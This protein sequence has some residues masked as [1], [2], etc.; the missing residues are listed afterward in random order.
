MEFHKIWS[1]NQTHL[2]HFIQ[3]KV[4]DK[5]LA[6]DILQEVSIKL[7]GSMDGRIKISNYRNWLFQVA[8]NTIADYY[9]KKG[10][11]D[12]LSEVN[13]NTDHSESA[14]VCDLSEF[15][16]Q[17][18]LAEK[19]S[20]PLYMSDILGLSQQHIADKLSISLS[21]TKSRIQRARVKLRELIDECLNISY[22]VHGQITDFELKKDCEIPQEL[23]D[24]MARIN[25]V[26]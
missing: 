14:C 20:R 13:M 1:T 15:V 8:R 24:E 10:K 18:Y 16:I 9:R 5:H 26:V 2:F 25:L 12:L 22:N 17:N 3:S 21:A 4:D 6:N 7:L 23:K 11:Q 19:Y